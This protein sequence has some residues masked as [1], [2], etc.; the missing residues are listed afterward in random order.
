MAKGVKKSPGPDRRTKAGGVRN[1]T[2][3]LGRPK[4]K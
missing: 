1:V 4:K 3:K 2:K